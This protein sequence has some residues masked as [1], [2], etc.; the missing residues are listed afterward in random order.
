MIYK[1]RITLILLFPVFLFAEVDLKDFNSIKQYIE[2]GAEY[3][4]EIS[5]F[6]SKNRAQ[7]ICLMLREKLDAQHN[8]KIET[9]NLEYKKLENEIPNSVFNKRRDIVIKN[10]KDSYTS[11]KKY[12]DAER[13]LI[14]ED[15]MGGTGAYYAA[16]LFEIKK[17]LE[18]I[19]NN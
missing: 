8:Q 15:Y 18:R 11:W 14:I 16:N 6:E 17:I 12:I 5:Y 3:E 19:S 1:I 4:N 13:N 7:E 9:I 2:N 10:T